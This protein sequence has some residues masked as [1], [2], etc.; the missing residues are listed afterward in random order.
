MSYRSVNPLGLKVM[1]DAEIA[2]Y[3]IIVLGWFNDR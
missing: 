3:H 2:P 1:N